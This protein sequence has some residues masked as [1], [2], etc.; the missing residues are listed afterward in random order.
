MTDRNADR[1]KA[2][3]AR[4]ESSTPE[5]REKLRQAYIAASSLQ[6]NLTMSKIHHLKELFRAAYSA[7]LKEVEAA[8]RGFLRD[9]RSAVYDAVTALLFEDY[10]LYGE[11]VL[12]NRAWANV[13][14][15]P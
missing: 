11:F 10:L 2:V 1:I 13:I 15:R 5:E 4:A 14:E 6:D 12:L 8:R 7:L 3:F 9:A